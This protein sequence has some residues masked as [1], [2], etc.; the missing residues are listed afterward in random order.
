MEHR[1]EHGSDAVA[2]FLEFGPVIASRDAPI[3]CRTVTVTYF[4]ELM[5]TKLSGVT[6]HRRTR[7]DLHWAW[8][9]LHD[10]TLILGIPGT[11]RHKHLRISAIRLEPRAP[12][13]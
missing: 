7:A 6:R 2:S 9:S 5:Q 8:H 11:E 13:V 4:R 1:R 12:S 3:M 10:P